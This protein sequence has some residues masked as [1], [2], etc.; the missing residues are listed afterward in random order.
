MKFT[1]KYAMKT[2]L[3]AAVC[4]SAM[5]IFAEEKVDQTST[6]AKLLAYKQAAINRLTG[7]KPAPA[8]T[9]TQKSAPVKAVDAQGHTMHVKQF[10]GKIK[11]NDT[12][13][14]VP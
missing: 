11:R 8:K 2:L 5:H 10:W 6:G 12:T 1:T 7:A 9:D 14:I 13:V 4:S 3:L